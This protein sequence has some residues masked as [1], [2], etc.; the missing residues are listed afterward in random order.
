MWNKIR[1][2]AALVAGVSA[3][4]LFILTV[5]YAVQVDNTVLAPYVVVLLGEAS[6][7]LLGDPA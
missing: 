3:V 6:W 1:Y 7:Y 5:I 4:A 2:A